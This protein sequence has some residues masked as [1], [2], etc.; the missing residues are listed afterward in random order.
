MISA[1]MTNTIQT[2]ER[3][4]QLFFIGYSVHTSVAQCS[5][6]LIAHPLVSEQCRTA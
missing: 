6:M 2:A 1:V 4:K 3:F 5:N